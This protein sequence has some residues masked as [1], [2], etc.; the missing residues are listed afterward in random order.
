MFDRETAG[1]TLRTFITENFFFGR[2]PEGFTADD[3][4]IELGVLDSTGV[5]ELVTFVEKEFG[6]EIVDDEL[7]PENLDS[8]NVLL[9]YLERKAAAPGE[10]SD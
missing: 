5:L 4:F 2:L 1:R 6:I 7:S 10:S 8:V 9:G 3:S